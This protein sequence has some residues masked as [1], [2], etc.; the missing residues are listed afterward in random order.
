[1]PN[2]TNKKLNYYI[3]YDL[4]LSFILIILSLVSWYIAINYKIDIVDFKSNEKNVFYADGG[5]AQMIFKTSNFVPDIFF[6][7]LFINT[8]VF[9]LLYIIQFK[10]FFRLT[11]LLLISPIIFVI[12][13]LISMNSSPT[14]GGKGHILSS[15]AWFVGVFNYLI[16]HNITN[17]W[18]IFKNKI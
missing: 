14:F 15:I 5:S 4:T 10:Q 6:L 2:L 8:L 13:F 18:I 3:K 11:F 16:I 7:G 9:L 17:L 12:C 1:M